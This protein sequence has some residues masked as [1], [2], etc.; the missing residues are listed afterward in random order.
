MKVY[1]VL[2]FFD[3]EGYD[4]PEYVFDSME[5]AVAKEDELKAEWPD[6]I[7]KIFEL[8]VA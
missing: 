3:Y 4:K 8:E 1:A 2:E 6:R 7:L 5:K